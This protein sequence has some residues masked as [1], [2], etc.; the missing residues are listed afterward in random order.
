M[1]SLGGPWVWLPTKSVLCSLSLSISSQNIHHSP[2]LETSPSFSSLPVPSSSSPVESFLEGSL[3]SIHLLAALLLSP[4]RAF[5]LLYLDYCIL[6]PFSLQSFATPTNFVR[7]CLI[8]YLKYHFATLLPSYHCLGLSTVLSV[9]IGTF[10]MLA[11]Q[12]CITTPPYFSHFVPWKHFYWLRKEYLL[13]VY[14]KIRGILNY[15]RKFCR[16]LK[17]TKNRLGGS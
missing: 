1:G 5:I 11:A 2:P 10:W 14:L 12:Y 7:C 17:H 4:H 8:C 9:I 13:C 16:T 3:Y 15:Q 6:L